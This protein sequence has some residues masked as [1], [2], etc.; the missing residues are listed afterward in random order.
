MAAV[1]QT[2]AQQEAWKHY[3]HENNLC[4]E[5]G[6]MEHEDETCEDY[7]ERQ[8]QEFEAYETLEEEAEESEDEEEPCICDENGQPPSY[9]DGMDMVCA[10]CREIC[11]EAK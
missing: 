4:V 10:T 1:A 9:E 5:C 6:M 11:A 3:A 2:D 7:A 8:Q